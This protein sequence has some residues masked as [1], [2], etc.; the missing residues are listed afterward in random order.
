M[1]LQPSTH[2]PFLAENLRPDDQYELSNGHAIQ[3]MPTGGRGSLAEGA[4]YKVL[5]TDQETEDI[6][7]D[8]GFS[9]TPDS[10]RAPDLSVGTIS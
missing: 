1:K 2:G 9:P 6:G 10:L 7:I 5:S 3:C 4:G 8:T